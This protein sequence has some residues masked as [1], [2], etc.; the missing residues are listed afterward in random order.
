MTKT[1]TP[2]TQTP[3]ELRAALGEAVG[4]AHVLTDA[5]D[6]A[7][8]LTEERGLWRGAARCVVLPGSTAEVSEIMK[9]ARARGWKIVPQGGNT[10]LVGGQ[11][12][13]P[14]GDEIVLSLK[15]M[16]KVREIARP[17]TRWSWRRA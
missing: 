11:T 15:R 5:R 12:P 3:E 9:R 1:D 10:G 17:P 14:R 2:N 7:G 8:F 4:D 16:N 13:S 6:M